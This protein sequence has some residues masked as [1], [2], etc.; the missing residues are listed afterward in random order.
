MVRLRDIR[1]LTKNK[2][3]KLAPIYYVQPGIRVGNRV[4]EARYIRLEGEELERM[5]GM[6]YFLYDDDRM[7]TVEEEAK[8]LV[9]KY[10]NRKN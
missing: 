1:Y 7:F 2:V 9:D 3:R 6:D 4:G 10:N 8:E 5:L